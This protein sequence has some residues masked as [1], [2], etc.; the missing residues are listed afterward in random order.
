MYVTDQPPFLN[1]AMI[2]EA[3]M[4]PREVLAL[5]KSVET[6][7]GRQ[8]GLRYGPRVLDL[9]LITYGSLIYRFEADGSTP[10]IVPHPDVAAR[11]FVL[12]PLAEISPDLHIPGKGRVAELLCTRELRQQQSGVRFHSTLRPLTPA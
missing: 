2:A 11:R 10:V 3:E 9:D 7:V 8:P 12:E 1:A 6:R 5:L 4:G